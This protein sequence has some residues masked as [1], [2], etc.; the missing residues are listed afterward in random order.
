MVN[1]RWKYFHKFAADVGMEDN[2]LA[3]IVSEMKV[4]EFVEFNE[5]RLYVQKKVHDKY[6]KLYTLS[7]T[8]QETNVL[9]RSPVYIK[10]PYCRRGLAEPLTMII[11]IVLAVGSTVV[12]VFFL[13]DIGDVLLIQESCRISSLEVIRTS[14]AGA[15]GETG[16]MRVTLQNDA[17]RDATVT[18]TF[19]TD[20]ILLWNTAVPPTSHQSYTWG[21]IKSREVSDRGIRIASTT[22]TT[23]IPDQVLLEATFQYTA[24]DSLSCTAEATVR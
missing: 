15:T 10:K 7:L 21:E 11:L 3:K 12:V 9:R 13:T 14:P 6:G 24:D 8:D 23:P 19:P 1:K 5:I 18:L 4:G 2:A 20:D 22:V 17:D 16:F